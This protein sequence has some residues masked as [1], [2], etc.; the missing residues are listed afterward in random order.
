MMT[1]EASGLHLAVSTQ[2]ASQ[3]VCVR[4]LMSADF[5]LRLLFLAPAGD[6][7]ARPALWLCQGP[8]TAFSFGSSGRTRS[9][10]SSL[11]GGILDLLLAQRVLSLFFPPQENSP[12]CLYFETPQFFF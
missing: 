7:A 6:S 9:A 8:V 12:W 3:C 5:F 1:S 4:W 2:R 11:F 10:C